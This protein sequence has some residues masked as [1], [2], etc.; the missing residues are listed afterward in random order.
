[1]KSDIQK[2]RTLNNQKLIF[3]F[4]PT[5]VGKTEL[6][7]DCFKD[8][9]E[10]V[11]ADSMQVYRYLDIGS[12]KPSSELMKSIPHHLV[13]ILNPW[14]QFTVGRFIE[15]ADKACALIWETGKIPVLTGGTAY[16]FK[17][18]LYGLSSLPQADMKIRDEVSNIIQEKGIDYLISFVEVVDPVSSQR[19]NK[20]D[21]YR[22][23]R[24]MEVYYQ[25]GKPLSSFEVPST[26]R[27]GMNPLVI[28]LNRDKEE[29][30]RRIEERVGIMFHSG[31]IEEMKGL[32]NM[33]ADSTWP[34]MQGIGYKEFI[35]A[36][37]DGECSG[38]SI[39]E[40]II[41]NTKKYAKRQLTFFRSFEG[42][43]WIEPPFTENVKALL[44]DYLN[45]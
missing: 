11:N 30:N 8:N 19:I 25:T 17:H 41:R 6:I 44:S 13:D 37:D 38:F 18:F 31:L 21:I 27:F 14:E 35:S 12:A 42:V 36:R 20:N 23:S 32:F 7:T 1:M 28:G 43:N 45:S 5:A 10:V 33:G 9:F 34:G 4:G 29:L 2:T 15:E 40:D 22:L 24:V 3:L 39:I 16:Y 26:P